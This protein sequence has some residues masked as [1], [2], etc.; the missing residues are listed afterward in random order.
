MKLTGTLR[1]RIQVMLST[2]LN[3]DG[4]ADPVRCRDFYKKA[5]VSLSPAAEE[6]YGKYSRLFD[7]YRIGFEKKEDSRSFHYALFPD[8]VG[9]KGLDLLKQAFCGEE[10]AAPASSYMYKA[11]A[12]AAGTQVTPIGVVG[13]ERSAMVYIDGNGVLY[14]VSIGRTEA[15]RHETMADML[16]DELAEHIPVKMIKRRVSKSPDGE[17]GGC[18]AALAG[19][20]WLED[21]GCL[22]ESLD[23]AAD[24]ALDSGCGC[25]GEAL[26][27][28][29]LSEIAIAIMIFTL[30]MR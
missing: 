28:G 25:M 7:N 14:T 18:L 19:F 11:A 24:L 26:G 15:R 5:Q 4:T 3:E 1:E 16:A 6:F 17:K 10:G 23:I 8:I 13:C 12:G 29:C 20:S 2:A 27:A 9:S 22:V 30:L 21:G